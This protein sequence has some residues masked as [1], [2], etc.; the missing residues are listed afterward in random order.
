MHAWQ[1]VTIVSSVAAVIAV[2]L[3]TTSREKR[4][5]DDVINDGTTGE[6]RVRLAR[7][8]NPN[9][10]D[11]DGWPLLVAILHRNHE[12]MRVLLAAGA[13]ANL[14]GPPPLLY[15]ESGRDHEAMRL[16]VAAG[17]DPNGGDLYEAP[18]HVAAHRQDAR[19][20]MLLLAAGAD[21][22]RRMR[23]QPALLWTAVGPESNATRAL[24]RSGADPN[25]AGRVTGTDAWELSMRFGT[26]ALSVAQLRGILAWTAMPPDAQADIV[27]EYRTRGSQRWESL[28]DA[29]NAGFGREPR[30]FDLLRDEL[31]SF[32]PLFG[33]ALACSHENVR[34]LL[35]AG[36]HPT[37]LNGTGVATAADVARLMGCADVAALIDATAAH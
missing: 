35:D 32:T 34:L 23:G 10:T 11:R 28:P 6:L 27:R 33:A 16:L 22:N 3:V 20:V 7:G 31:G 9:G 2:V 36:A 18:L 14:G 24:L 30:K 29:A 15:A 25:A 1:I 21:P 37:T 8:E 4:T 17:A 5:L 19:G 13:D 12:A 26:R